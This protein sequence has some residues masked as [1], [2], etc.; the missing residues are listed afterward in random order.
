MAKS[1]KE[2]AAAGEKLTSQQVYDIITTYIQEQVALSQREMLSKVNFELPSW[3]EYQAYQLG[4]IKGLNKI[5]EYI[6]TLT[7]GKEIG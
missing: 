5:L 1:L 7:K 3:S 4:T 2:Y 6:P